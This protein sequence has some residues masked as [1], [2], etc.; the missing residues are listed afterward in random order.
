MTEILIIIIIF[1]LFVKNNL[2]VALLYNFF[3]S[4]KLFDQTFFERCT[5]FWNNNNDILRHYVSQ[6]KFIGSIIIIVTCYL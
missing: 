4:I 1:I 5:D 6:M 3:S 2:F